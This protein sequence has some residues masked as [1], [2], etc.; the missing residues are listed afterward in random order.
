MLV[1]VLVPPMWMSRTCGRLL[2][3]LGN[4]GAE[5]ELLKLSLQ[6]GSRYKCAVQAGRLAVLERAGASHT[7]LV[8]HAGNQVFQG[9]SRP[10]ASRAVEI[11]SAGIDICFLQ[12][13]T[14]NSGGRSESNS[15]TLF[16]F[17]LFFRMSSLRVYLSFDHHTQLRLSV[18]LRRRVRVSP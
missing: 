12:G 17:S 1:L 5:L 15:C 11:T 18:F 6:M 9:E 10:I 2:G 14:G 8:G 7:P 3:A 13:C 4:T 16:L